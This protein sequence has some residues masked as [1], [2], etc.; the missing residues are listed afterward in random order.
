MTPLGNFIKLNP[1]CQL[2]HRWEAT[3]WAAK[4]SAKAS[5]PFCILFIYTYSRLAKK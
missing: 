4:K 3:V 5:V 1:C 2:N